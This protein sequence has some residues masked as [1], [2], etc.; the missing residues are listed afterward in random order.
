ML[1]KQVNCIL[2]FNLCSV[3][4]SGGRKI[5]VGCSSCEEPA[6]LIVKEIGRM[7]RY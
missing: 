3:E 7:W 6:E 1:M 2:L 4:L 5:D